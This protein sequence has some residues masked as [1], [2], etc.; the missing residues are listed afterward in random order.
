MRTQGSHAL[1]M[2]AHR[3]GVTII[4]LLTSIFALS[5]SLSACD[6]LASDKEIL[7]SATTTDP[8]Y[9][10][11]GAELIETDE[12]GV[13]RY[14]LIADRIAQNPASLVIEADHPILDVHDDG[15]VAW[16]VSA[17]H[18]RLPAN[19]RIMQLD[20]QV[21]VVS[22]RENDGPTLTLDTETL[23]YDL[24]NGVAETDATVTLVVDG[25]PLQ[26]TGLEADLRSRRV[27]LHESVQGRF[28]P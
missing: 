28:Q 26:G 2:M 19:T 14:R 4:T 27:R 3:R 10:V 25:H 7:P 13:P 5:M 21:N 11:I 23:R 1:S 18:G 6:Q 12:L 9:V 22:T 8:G 24:L 15:S 16:R 17:S 20:G